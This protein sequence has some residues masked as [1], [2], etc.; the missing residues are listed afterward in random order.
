MV[1]A[2]LC[3]LA[4]HH[5][6]KV[7]NAN[8][9]SSS[10]VTDG[11]GVLGTQERCYL[12][13]FDGEQPSVLHVPAGSAVIGRSAEADLVLPNPSV[14]RRH[15]RLTIDPAEALLEDLDSQ[16][17]TCVNGR[18]IGAPAR[19]EPGDVIA[20][21][22]VTLAFHR[23]TP[24][25]TGRALGTA[26]QFRRR[27]DDDLARSLRYDRPLTLVALE[28]GRPAETAEQADIAGSLLGCLRLLDALVWLDAGI[29]LVLLAEAGAEGGRKTAERLLAVLKSFASAARGGTATWPTDG[30]S[31]DALES[32]ALGAADSAAPGTLA[33]A[34]CGPTIQKVGGKTVI[35]SD[36]S[37]IRVFAL[38]ERLGKSSLPVLIQGETGVGKEIA[39]LALHEF[40]SRG[41]RFIAINCAAL[42]DNL[43]ESELFGHE[44]GAFSGA[45]A[46][47]PGL[48][49]AA[50]G[51]TVFLDEVGE[52]GA[53]AQ[54][55][56]LR[57]IE[58]RRA[59]RLGSLREY[60]IEVRL[61]AATNR[62]LEAEVAAGRFRRD[63]FFRLGA[64]TVT[65][66]PLRERPRDL[67]LLARALL[68]ESCA[69]VGREPMMLS[70]RAMSALSAYDWPGNVRELKNLME[71]LAA[72]VFEPVLE[73]E[74]LPER[75][76]SAAQPE[77][78]L[79]EPPAAPGEPSSS[80]PASFRKLYDEIGELERARIV[81]ALEAA[82][83]VQAR[84]A[85]LIGLPLRTFFSKMKEHDIV[86]P[87]RRRRG[88]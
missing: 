26:Q 70:A 87:P 62:D 23:G 49:E 12:I 32:A 84:A 34:V 79:P 29:V 19:L 11:F 82:G 47:K 68:G 44:K 60:P 78:A 10:T 42:P 75:L 13:L 45:D 37:V 43:L 64:A 73:P 46:A 21:G 71:Y 56:L 76:R 7:T 88:S 66:P 39:A 55:K 1:G 4:E 20:V 83:G 58:T 18:R 63:L 31:A 69:H 22:A 14:S 74:H 85:E 80:A 50:A 6:H 30:Q 8:H 40:A 77:P 86:P 65:L 36:A 28:L 9:W 59:S 61:V 17:G 67:P 5:M 38:L 27:V 54:A 81:Q 25:S 3:S 51:G 35:V 41:G 53:S 16:N 57:V 2:L 24:P 52:L 72:T 33:A 48:L 15:A